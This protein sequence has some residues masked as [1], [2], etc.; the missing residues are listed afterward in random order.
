MTEAWKHYERL[1]EVI[2]ELNGI[3]IPGMI[4]SPTERAR[5]PSDKSIYKRGHISIYKIL[6]IN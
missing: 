5:S 6:I 4:P 1:R 3:G 2:T